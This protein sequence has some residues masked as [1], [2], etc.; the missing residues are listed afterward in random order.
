MIQ[1]VYSKKFIKLYDNLI[2]DL[3]IEV[4]I[5]IEKFKNIENHK[6]LK[7]HKL[8]GKMKDSYSFSVDYKHRIIFRYLDKNTAVLMAFGDHQ[9][10]Q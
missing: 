8:H 3:K 7:V 4:K 1:V 6:Q 9:I 10:Y 5:T 2:N